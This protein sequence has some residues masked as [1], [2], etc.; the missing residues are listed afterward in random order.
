M[1]T[2]IFVIILLVK[3]LL[4]K[5]ILV[6][7]FGLKTNSWTYRNKDSTG[8]ELIGSFY[9]EKLWAIIQ[10]QTVK[11]EIK[12]KYYWSCWIM[13]PKELDYARN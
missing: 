3:N 13:L 8:K 4:A 5:K 12:S 10:G 2:I 6:I 1:N 9:K 11:L 7:D